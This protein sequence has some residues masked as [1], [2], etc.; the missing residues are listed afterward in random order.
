[1]PRPTP[2]SSS[3]CSECSGL[4]AKALLVVYSC[5]QGQWSLGDRDMERDVIPMAQ[6][7]GMAIGGST[8][9]GS[10]PWLTRR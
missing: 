4:T 9:A 3:S 8:A 5:S 10:D 6:S 1:M 7:F 2:L